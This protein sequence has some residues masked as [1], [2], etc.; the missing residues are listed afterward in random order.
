MNVDLLYDE[1][2]PNWRTVA[3]NLSE[4]LDEV[5]FTLQFREFST[6]GAA[7]AALY[8]GSPTI[9]VDGHDPFASVGEHVDAAC[10]IYL[11]PEGIGGAPTLDQLRAAITA[12]GSST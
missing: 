10:R 11:T 4:L 3:G 8:R 7:Q 1:G 5:A 12:E 6:L 9:L 2:C